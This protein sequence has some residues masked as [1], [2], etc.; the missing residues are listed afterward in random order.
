MKQ[1][2]IANKKINEKKTFYI[3]KKPG[4]FTTLSEH[5]TNNLFIKQTLTD[6]QRKNKIIK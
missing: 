1:K 4:N 5:Y 2:L 6:V 3:K